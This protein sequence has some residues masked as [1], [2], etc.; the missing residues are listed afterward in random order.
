MVP[1]LDSVYFIQ[2]E[3]RE[4]QLAV[5]EMTQNRPSSSEIEAQPPVDSTDYDLFNLAVRKKEPVRLDSDVGP[6]IHQTASPHGGMKEDTIS[7]SPPKSSSDGIAT[8]TP[9]HIPPATVAAEES[10]ASEVTAAAPTRAEEAA[11]NGG[12]ELVGSTAAVQE[13]GEGEQKPK[14]GRPKKTQN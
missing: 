8:S 2:A 10:S 12:G 11:E 5:P 1:I 9:E 6:I 3:K 14:R 7:K 4:R 13:P